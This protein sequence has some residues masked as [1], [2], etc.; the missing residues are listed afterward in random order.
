LVDA[1]HSPF[2]DVMNTAIEDLEGEENE[3]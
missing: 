1:H 3:K 2:D